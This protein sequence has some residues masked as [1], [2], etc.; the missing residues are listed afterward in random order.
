MTG[1]T[2]PV[3]TIRVRREKTCP[4]RFIKVTDKGP[5][6]GQWMR[7]ARW[8][9]LQNKGPIPAGKMVIHVDG[10]SLNDDPKNLILGTASDKMYLSHKN[11]P[12]MSAR[13]RI[14]CS[15][16]TAEHNRLRSRVRRTLGWL[17]TRWYGVDHV[18]RCIHNQPSKVRAGVWRQLGFDF[19][20]ALNGRGV[21]SLVLGFASM[22]LLQALIL[23]VLIEAGE[24]ITTDTLIER[25]E[26]HRQDRYLERLQAK[27]PV[28]SALS[29]LR[30][31]GLICSRQMGKAPGLHRAT[32]LAVDI[33]TRWTVIV[34]RRGSELSDE[35]YA[36]YTKLDPEL[37]ARSR[38][39]TRDSLN[40]LARAI[41]EQGIPH[42]Q[43]DHSEEVEEVL[44]D[45]EEA[46]GEEGE[47]QDAA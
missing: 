14:A 32:S 26:G 37:G 30:T 11:D 42:A 20:I 27:G 16:A 6:Q 43:D 46:A 10:D 35:K 45:L 33:R 2:D 12:E 47:E 38:V 5:P 8:W 31:A 9:W 23:H 40:M 36:D 7:Y 15:A 34:P 18:N 24:G 21:D 4:V 17:P 13:N 44:R 1:T 25:V 28:Y 39:A 29:A 41:A 19:Y 22:P 3:G